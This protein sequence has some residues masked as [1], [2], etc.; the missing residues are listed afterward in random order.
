MNESV[1]PSSRAIRL[2][3]YTLRRLR[4]ALLGPIFGETAISGKRTFDRLP[5]R[6]AALFAG[7]MDALEW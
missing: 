6:T 7:L 5:A 3:H 2:T 4:W 1:W